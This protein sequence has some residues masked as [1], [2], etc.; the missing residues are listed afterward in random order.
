MPEGNVVIVGGGHGGF[1][2][3]VALREAGYRGAVTLIT[4]E[5]VLPYQ[6]P[7]LSKAYLTGKT[8]AAKLAFR[9]C[10]FFE[11]KQ[12]DLRIGDRAEA[13]DR[14]NN[15][16]T[17]ASGAAVPYTHLIL[18]SGATPTSLPIRTIDT[19]GVLYLR[20]LCDAEKLRK[21]LQA[22]H[23]VV[24]VGGGFIGL[25]VAAL[26]TVHN[27]DV[28]V[29]E[30][31]PRLLSRSVTSTTSEFFFRQHQRWGARIL[32]ATG[33]DD[34]LR[35]ED[36][37]ICAVRL[38]DGSILEADLLLVGVGATPNTALAAESG[39]AVQDGVLVDEYL[40]TS[41]P[42]IYAIGDCA[43]YPGG[44][45]E[46]NVR[47][48]SV[49]NAVDQARC[50]ATTLTATPQPYR[51]VPLF[52]SD[53]QDCKLQIAGEFAEHD[54]LAV[55]GDI[56]AARFSV[57]AFWRGTLVAVESVNRPA[58]HIAARTLLSTPIP[59]LKPAQ[60]TRQFDL[61]SHLRR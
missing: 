12:I 13:L 17:L 10:E 56:D 35:A 27:H 57:Y 28:T 3:A 8:D 9:P 7:P 47:R 24:V 21:R 33:V 41:D 15:V 52:W 61:S 16:V 31:M 11:C 29:V 39:L 36:G 18:S 51:K 45:D 14:I 2:A 42:A 30:R 4:D 37:A 44:P 38:S 50:I 22:A 54:T 48:E 32:L 59:Q 19:D 58:D 46:N 1:T 5:D 20:Q 55:A 43:R 23:K 6:R 49:Q 34:F 40:R 26:A 53:Q 25:E 60:I